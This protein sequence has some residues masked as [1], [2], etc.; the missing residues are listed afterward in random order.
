MEST[1]MMAIEKYTRKEL[2]DL[3]GGGNAHRGFDDIVRDFPNKLLGRRPEGLL[4][5]AWEL[6]EHMRIA[7]NDILEF[8]RNPGY[9]SPSW[10]AGYWP[11]D[12]APPN[13]KAC[14]KSIK[15]FL[16]DRQALLDLVADTRNRLDEPFPH[17]DGQTLMH[18]ALLV[19]NHTAYHLGQLV[20][21]RRLLNEWND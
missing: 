17:G 12:P 8:I 15:E 16:A 18:E 7:Q 14:D 13:D 10:P 4:Y 1:Q 21:V 5:S 2:A 20:V 19:C 3:L 9:E 11:K 6:I